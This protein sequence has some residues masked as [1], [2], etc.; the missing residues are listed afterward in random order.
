MALPKGR[1]LKDTRALLQEA[2]LEWEDLPDSDRRL[3]HPVR[4][5]DGT[6]AEVLILR[7]SDVAAYV[8]R[9]VCDLGVAGYDT[10]VEQHADVF[11][12]LDLQFAK[13]RMV[14]AGFPDIDPLA[15]ENPRI[16]T[17]YPRIA[18]DYFLSQGAPAKII[19]L[20]GAVEIAPLVGL[21]DAI[22]DIVETGSTLRTHGLVEHQTIF[23]ISAR[24][25]VNRAALRLRARAIRNIETRLERVLNARAEEAVCP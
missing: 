12:P 16:A 7:A 19:A 15:L 13:C 23:E 21:S 11:I 17:K 24:L 4:L 22:V 1:V 3:I 5:P 9:G 2:G 25:V 6:D 14:V 18:Q 8:E 10:I 20:S